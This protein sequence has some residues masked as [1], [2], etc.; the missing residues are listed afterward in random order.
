MEWFFDA[1]GPIEA[2]IVVPAGEVQIDEGPADRVIVTLEPAGQTSPQREDVIAASEVSFTDG[3][4]RVR[5]PERSSREWEIHGHK[6]VVS[7][8]GIS[9][10][11]FDV[12]CRIA[13]PPSSS[14]T[15]TTSSAD[16]TCRVSLERFRST[17]AS[18]DIS[19]TDVEDSL[20]VK[21]ASGDVDGRT[22]GSLQITGASSDV[23]IE[24]VR[25]EA[26]VTTASGDVTLGE[27]EASVIVKTAS[28]DVRVARALKGR[29]NTNT[30]SGDISIGVAHG[31]GA[32]LDV[33]SISGDMSCNVPVEDVSLSEAQLDIV[34]RTVSGD[35]EIEAA[36]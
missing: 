27:A 35:V 17:T 10:G 8:P 32:H 12:N 11:T 28:G 29:L 6:L 18:G 21:S 5:V 25:D 20:V 3:R 2:E 9:F 22:V 33:T 23:R 31:V 30:A 34:C 36:R 7:I 24:R 19:F 14:V 13:L 26:R 16:V 15:T 1:H 4:L